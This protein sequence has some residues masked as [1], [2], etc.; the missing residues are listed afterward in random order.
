MFVGIADDSG[1]S[2]RDDFFII[3]RLAFVSCVPPGDRR[4]QANQIWDERGTRDRKLAQP[5][6][7]YNVRSTGQQQQAVAYVSHFLSFFFFF[8]FLLSSRFKWQSHHWPLCLLLVNSLRTDQTNSD[9]II[10]CTLHNCGRS[11]GW[12]PSPPPFC[13]KTL[14]SVW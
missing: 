2:W 13:R 6:D 11:V 3:G 4:R 8:F 1:D 7:T 9:F 14:I 12:A 5:D 10:A